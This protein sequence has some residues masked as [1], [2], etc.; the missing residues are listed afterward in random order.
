[1]LGCRYN[2]KNTLD[3]NY[4]HLAQNFGAMIQAE[5]E[6]Y[7]VIPVKTADGANGYRI[8]WQ[9]SMKLFKMSREQD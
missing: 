3:K 6:V 2:A 1:M 9:S 5:S 7:D 4:L 8:K